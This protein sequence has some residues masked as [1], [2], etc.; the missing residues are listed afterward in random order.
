[1]NPRGLTVELCKVGPRSACF[2]NTGCNPKMETFS[3]FGECFGVVL[4]LY[5]I[6]LQKI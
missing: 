1:M 4:V 6:D 2:Y 3:R 5:Y